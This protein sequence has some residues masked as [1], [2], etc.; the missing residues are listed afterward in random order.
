M[1]V[2]GFPV[3]LRQC[4]VKDQKDTRNKLKRTSDLTCCICFKIKLK[5][6]S[7][8]LFSWKTTFMSPLYLHYTH[9]LLNPVDIDY[10]RSVYV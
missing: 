7:N 8:I 4:D 5:V 1:E 2:T 6:R 10:L 3:L 9:R